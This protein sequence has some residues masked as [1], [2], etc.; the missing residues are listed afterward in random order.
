SFRNHRDNMPRAIQFLAL[1]ADHPNPAGIGVRLHSVKVEYAPPAE[2][3]T[4][5][6]QPIEQSIR[7]QFVD[8]NAVA[9][10]HRLPLRELFDST[11]GPP[12]AWN[13]NV[14]E[15]TVVVRINVA[16]RARRR[17]LVA[18]AMFD[19]EIVDDLA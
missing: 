1:R 19:V 6:D 11:A 14:G 8:R 10:L 17:R 5:V 3:G 15:T 13:V 12:D 4:E 7:G 2:A 18:R 9:N 16:V